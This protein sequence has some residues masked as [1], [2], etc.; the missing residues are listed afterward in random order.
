MIVE[1]ACEM[2]AAHYDADTQR[3]KHGRQTTCSRA[4]S[5]LLRAQ[6]HRKPDHEKFDQKAYNATYYKQNRN[7]L[8]DAQKQ[9]RLS[10]LD[11]T[12][13]M[14]RAH[15]RLNREKSNQRAS[16]WYYA[17]KQLMIDR[18][19]LWKRLN[20]D[21]VQVNTRDY[22]SRRSGATGRFTARDYERLKN[23]LFGLCGYCF[24]SPA[25]TIDHIIPLSRNGSNFI[26]NIMPACGNCNYS[27]GP[28]TIVEWK[29]GHQS[30]R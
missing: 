12:R 21:K 15:Q 3:L 24:A 1:R 20:P 28:K 6:K 11:R 22:A 25:N 29:Y 2:C 19:K 17:N 18:A 14:A 9:Y 5:Y 23:R 10:N 4:C 13:A 27:K 26:G 30:L 8:L 16:D 7:R